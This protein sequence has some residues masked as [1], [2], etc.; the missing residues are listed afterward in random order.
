[1]SETQAEATEPTAA[2]E[3]DAID[4]ADV[5]WRDTA[6]ALQAMVS[7]LGANNRRL[8]DEAAK[9]EEDTPRIDWSA[10]RE[11]RADVISMLAPLC[12]CSYDS[13]STAYGPQ[14]E[15]PL[16]G[17]GE[18]FVRHVQ[19]QEGELVQARGYISDLESR[20]VERENLRRML[21][22]LCPC[23]TEG[24]AMRE[25]PLHGD[26]EGFVEWFKHLEANNSAVL[27]LRI[28]DRPDQPL[29]PWPEATQDQ[30]LIAKHF[31]QARRDAAE[32][33]E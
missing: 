4:S 8:R 23:H 10:S 18:T 30:A 32:D 2:E 22:S 5:D 13:N 19:E 31:D 11:A 17:D 14:R 24:A 16:H 27:L 29:L 15:C 9:V 21:W 1:M 28:L 6:R 20:D 12:P 7:E 26:G 3:A 33:N 25:C